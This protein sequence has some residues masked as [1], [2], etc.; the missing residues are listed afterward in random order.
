MEYI[1]G[2]VRKLTFVVTLLVIDKK[3]KFIMS[4]FPFHHGNDGTL[5]EAYLKKIVFILDRVSTSEVDSVG[6][7]GE[8]IVSACHDEWERR[9]GWL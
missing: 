8:S 1:P 7:S 6:M 5:I 9:L 2:N 4:D 3:G